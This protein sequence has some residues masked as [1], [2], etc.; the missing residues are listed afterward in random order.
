MAGQKAYFNGIE[1]KTGDYF[2]DPMTIEEIATRVSLGEEDKRHLVFLRNVLKQFRIPRLGT[3]YGVDPNNLEETGWGIIFHQNVSAEIRVSLKDLIEQRNG[4]VFDYLSGESKDHWLRRHGVGPGSV[5]PKRIPYYLL[6]IGQ[7]T[8]IP[9]EFQYQ[10]DVQYAV[11]RLSFDRPEE[12]A[13]YAKSVIEYE[14]NS[15]SN[16]QRKIGVFS[17]AHDGD[18]ATQISSQYLAEPVFTELSA[19][20][21]W[22]C[23]SYIG[24]KAT[25]GNL[26]QELLS[27]KSDI[28][29][30]FAACHGLGYRAGEAEQAKNQ[31]AWVCQDWPGRGGVQEEYIFSQADVNEKLSVF[32][33]MF[34]I[35]SCFGA[36]TP[37]TDDFSSQRTT[38]APKPFV[39]SLP[40]KLLSHPA[41]GALAYIGHI[42]RAW[43]YSFIWGDAGSQPQTII[44]TLGHIM[45]GARI[46]HA[47][48][49]INI[50]YAE[51]STMLTDALHEGKSGG[52]QPNAILSQTYLWA[53]RNDARNYVLIGDPAVRLA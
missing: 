20:A 3:I 4:K 51:L 39:A 41:G 43:G 53:A 31:G 14:K 27:A 13:R 21:K 23:T 52:A 35:F 17:T 11:G 44:S 2:T 50:R 32:G 33:K 5:D 48:N 15:P 25:K 36:G 1:A 7:P 8:E 37:S 24:D 9:F 29:L 12:Y 26:V 18:R 46:G 28:S 10:L 34:F 45:S 40:K 16:S 22:S 42:D 47:M 49:D 38:I 6:I 19:N 30:V